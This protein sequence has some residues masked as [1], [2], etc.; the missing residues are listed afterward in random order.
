MNKAVVVFSGGQD[1]TT[2]LGIAL[3]LGF[4]V[5]AIAFNYGQR[6]AVEL[7]QAQKICDL[8]KVPLKIV[9]ITEFG[10]LVARATALVGKGEVSDASPLAQMVNVPASFVPNRNAVMLTIAHGYA[11]MIGAQMLYT[12]VCQTD[13]S[14]Y[15]D[16]R[17]QF[18]VSLES[19]LNIG[20]NSNIHIATPLMHLTKGETFKLA[21]E[22]GILDMVINES[23]TCYEGIREQM[24]YDDS[25]SPCGV[26][27]SKHAWGHGCGECPACK[28]RA[29]GWADYKAMVHIAEGNP[30]EPRTQG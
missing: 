20:Y 29:K 12:G 23:H 30:Q 19:A 5:E 4:E 14:G 22:V 25:G 15:P 2:C 8:L 18:I 6:H 16:C 28:L 10:K 9:D 26:S 7:Q 17:H 13:Y 24:E 1:S 11:Q 3:H 27:D 21:A